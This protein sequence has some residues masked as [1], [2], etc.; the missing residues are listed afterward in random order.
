MGYE[1]AS[2]TASLAR[3]WVA[4]LA[5]AVETVY[6]DFL[7][8]HRLSSP[9]LLFVV[10]RLLNPLLTIPSLPSPLTLVVW[11]RSFVPF[12]ILFFF[13]FNHVV[14]VTLTSLLSATISIEYPGLEPVRILH[15]VE[16]FGR[17]AQ[18]GKSFK[19]KNV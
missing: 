6:K 7:A 1:V 18:L 3:A 5:L 17:G 13:D 14:S 12:I 19:N 11:C 8:L 16:Y 15:L 9:S 4:G 10:G 2:V